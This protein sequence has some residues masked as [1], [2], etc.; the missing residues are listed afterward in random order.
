[1]K[2]SEL[3]NFRAKAVAVE[4]AKRGET[5]LNDYFRVTNSMADCVVIGLI[6]YLIELG[7]IDEV[8]PGEDE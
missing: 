2:L 7:V 5:T 4:L 6:D 1:M 3:N 8:P